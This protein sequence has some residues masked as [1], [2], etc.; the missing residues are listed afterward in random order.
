MGAPDLDEAQLLRLEEQ[1][2][3]CLAA[4]GEVLT[5]SGFT[6]GFV[7]TTVGDIRGHIAARVAAVLHGRCEA[8]GRDV[9]R[10]PLRGGRRRA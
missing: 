6:A 4:L 2:A 3:E 10:Q 1:L 9:A 8:P 5:S 7:V